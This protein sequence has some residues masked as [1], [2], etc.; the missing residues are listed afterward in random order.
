MWSLRGDM[1]PVG[2]SILGVQFVREPGSGGGPIRA[3]QFLVHA[4][5]LRPLVRD[6]NE[7]VVTTSTSA[8]MSDDGKVMSPR[9]AAWIGA[10][11]IA[12][13]VVAVAVV[14][15]LARRRR[16]RR[17]AGLGK[18]HALE[19]GQLGAAEVE[20]KGGLVEVG[21]GGDEDESQV[22]HAELA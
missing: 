12:A 18:W 11:F 19:E 20:V 22:L 21:V 1:D 16:R 13:V 10:G 6:P 3:L 5:P 15:G 8:S 17:M 9:D 4:P 2:L 14:M 7:K